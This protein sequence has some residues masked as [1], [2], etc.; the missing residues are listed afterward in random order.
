MEEI[1][2]D[3]QSSELPGQDSL[4]SIDDMITEPAA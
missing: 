3:D 2:S 1:M 4:L